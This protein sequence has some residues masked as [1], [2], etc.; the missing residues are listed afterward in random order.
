[1][2]FT[3]VDTHEMKA[4][5]F[6]FGDTHEMKAVV[7]TLGDTHEMKAVVFTFRDTV[8]VWVALHAG[9]THTPLLFAC[10]LWST[11]TTAGCARSCVCGNRVF[12]TALYS[13]R[14]QA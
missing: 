12:S 3:L 4:V 2:V 8:Q 11:E 7:F 1:M 13:L 5:V 14:W 9:W 6:T 10:G